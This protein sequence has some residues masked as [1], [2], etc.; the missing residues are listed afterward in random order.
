MY[1]VEDM[2][3]KYLC[4]IIYHKCCACIHH[5]VCSCLDCS[6]KWNMCKHIHLVCR[7]INSNPICNQEEPE[8]LPGNV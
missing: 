2:Q 8:S 5:F 6:I 3:V 1:I 4:K 7:F